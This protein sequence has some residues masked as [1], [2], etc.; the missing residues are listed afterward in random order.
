MVLTSK[1]LAGAIRSINGNSTK[2]REA[3]QEALISCAYYAAKDGQV[4]PFNDLLQAVGTATRIQGLSLWAETWGFV[5][6]KNGKFAVNASAR[7][8]QN[9]TSETDFADYEDTIRAAAPWFDMM[10]KQVATSMFDAS[11]YLD[12]VIAK[13]DKEGANDAKAFLLEA[14]QKYKQAD[15]LIKMKLAAMDECLL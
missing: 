7:K 15:A 4:T 2:L 6:V 1:Q 10:P 9:I 5:R 8:E 14:V 12:H 3:I 11:V 13:L